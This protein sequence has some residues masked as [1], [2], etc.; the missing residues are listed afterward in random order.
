MLHGMWKVAF[1]TAAFVLSASPLDAA[2]EGKRPQ[3]EAR[4]DLRRDVERIS[5]EIYR[6]RSDFTSP[7]KSFA[8]GAAAKKR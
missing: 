6:P 2:Q 5:K 8:A 4:P 1:I 7:G 3:R